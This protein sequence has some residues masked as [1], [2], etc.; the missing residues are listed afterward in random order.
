VVDLVQGESRVLDGLVKGLTTTLDEARGELVE[1]GARQL[2]V[3][4]LGPSAVAVMKA[5]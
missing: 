3:E 2:E 5:G 4:V 1:L